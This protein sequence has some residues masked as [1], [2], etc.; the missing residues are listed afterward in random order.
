[1]PKASLPAS[2]ASRAPATLS[3]SQ[4]IFVAEKYGSS[5][6]PV[7]SV[8]SFSWPA[9]ASAAQ[10]SCV[11]RSCQTIALWIGLPVARSQ[12]IVVSRWLVMPIAATSSAVT[13]ALAIAARAV[14]T[15]VVQ[16]P[17]GSCS[18]QPGAG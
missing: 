4:A 9:R 13:S 6:R 5:S 10:A 12:M 15:A 1:M 7:R 11:R 18:T 16:M 14:A 3:S 2:A 17:C 8:T